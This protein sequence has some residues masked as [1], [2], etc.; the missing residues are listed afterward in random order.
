[1]S[2]PKSPAIGPNCWAA[3]TLLIPRQ[4]VEMTGAVAFRNLSMLTD[5]QL[6]ELD[7]TIVDHQIA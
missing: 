3:T 7:P 5:G 4:A 2:D 1:M 6:I